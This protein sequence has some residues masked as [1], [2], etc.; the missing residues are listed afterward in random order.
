M[1]ADFLFD[2]SQLM[3]DTDS[4]SDVIQVDRV[5][6]ENPFFDFSFLRVEY[7]HQTEANGVVVDGYRFYALT[8]VLASTSWWDG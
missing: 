4:A 6:I 2:G 7:G 3:I 1:A 5:E 8:V